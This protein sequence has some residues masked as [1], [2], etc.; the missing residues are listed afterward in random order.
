MYRQHC[1]S[2]WHR[3]SCVG[4]ESAMG[5]PAPLVCSIQHWCCVVCGTL[6][7]KTT[8]APLLCYAAIFVIDLHRS[9]IASFYQNDGPAGLLGGQMRRRRACFVVSGLGSGV[10][11]TTTTCG[12]SPPC[13]AGVRIVCFAAVRGWLSRGSRTA[14]SEG[15]IGGASQPRCSKLLQRSA[16]ATAIWSTTSSKNMLATWHTRW[17]SRKCRAMR[18]VSHIQAPYPAVDRIPESKC[19]IEV[20]P[21]CARFIARCEGPLIRQMCKQLRVGG[22][23]LTRGWP[24]SPR[25]RHHRHR[26]RE[27]RAVDDTSNNL[28][29]TTRC[30]GTTFTTEV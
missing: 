6:T 4:F 17:E 8:N 2:C 9:S 16:K 21:R 25:A 29:T 20:K 7:Q 15:C 27:P 19:N 1:S 13:K 12:L 26:V 14:C 18:S 23:C 5:S 11:F 30:S 28:L 10:P 22:A 24:R 3:G